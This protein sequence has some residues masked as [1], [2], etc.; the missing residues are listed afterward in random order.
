MDELGGVAKNFKGGGGGHKLK[1]S[2]E[3][4]IFQSLISV[5][6]FFTK[7]QKQKE[8]SMARSS[9]VNAPLCKLF[10]LVLII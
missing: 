3:S 10:I 4:G 9:P 2:N 8:G 5:C 6:S 7:R 1:P